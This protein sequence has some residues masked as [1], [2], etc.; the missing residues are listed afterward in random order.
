M[1]SRI[2]KFGIRIAALALCL[3]SVSL[4]LA[5]CDLDAIENYIADYTVA[6][7]GSGN[8]A[9]R[10]YDNI[11]YDPVTD[12]ADVT[13][14]DVIE[15]N[16]RYNPPSTT[17]KPQGAITP[18]TTDNIPA[19]FKEHVYLLHKNTGRCKELIGN[20][21][22]TVIITND[23]KTSWDSTSRN[24]LILSLSEQEKI[25]EA[26]AQS[27][28]KELDIT[29]SFID[30]TISSSAEAS[31]LNLWEEDAI[32][33]AGF[34]TK[35]GA[36][37]ELDDSNDAD[38]NPIVIALNMDG[39]PYARHQKNERSSELLVIYTSALYGFR[40][41]LYHLYGAED[42]YYPA[43]VKTLADQH[44]PD[45][46]MNEG[47]I[48]DSLTAFIIGWDD[49]LN[50]NA[51]EFLKET[52]H[53]TEEYLDAENEREMYTGLVSNHR[54]SYGT[55]SGYLEHGVPSG[56]GTLI[57]NE[58]GK[59]EGYFVN[60]NYHGEGTRVWADGNV[61]KG[62]WDNNK[63]HGKGTYTWT[64]GDSYTGNWVY[65]KIEGN[66]KYTWASGTYYDGAWV[67][68]DFEGQGT[69]SDPSGYKYVG[70]W[71][72][73]EK[74]GYGKLT[75][76]NGSVYEG[77][78]VNGECEG[79]GTIRYSNGDS[80]TGD[81][82]AGKMHGQGTYNF[83]YGH[84]YVGAWDNGNRTGYGV[85]TWT[86]GSSYDGYWL[87]NKRHGYGKYINQYGNVFEG[88]WANDIFQN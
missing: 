23:K 70:S 49:E 48:T 16:T 5:S 72:N 85:M 40:H 22:V 83:A 29:F 64:S 73:G 76:S 59:Y 66:G 45:S 71:K 51:A 61:Y 62:N 3:L 15:E 79:N 34:T 21:N 35:T 9:E 41:E 1:N 37:K 74:H 10:T 69:Y 13:V 42:F 6:G 43:E 56:Y 65:D 68:G 75:Y 25:L 36:Q 53:L 30:V 39:R 57:Y 54:L 4:S 60:G 28:G 11:D 14:T 58:G 50:S 31:L 8:N 19:E 88:Q 63:K 86:D 55:Y 20:V 7:T 84:K 77:N 38:S 80:Y 27:Y 52:S 87:N 2:K 12:P 78:F 33:A 46:I 67:N 18:E 32:K 26:D 47:D 24:E 17:K 44:L 82:K 81:W